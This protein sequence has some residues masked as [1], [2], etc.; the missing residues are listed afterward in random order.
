MRWVQQPVSQEAG[1]WRWRRHHLFVFSAATPAACSTALPAPSSALEPAHLGGLGGA[2]LDADAAQGLAELA[3]AAARGGRPG[4][5]ARRAEACATLLG[6]LRPGRQLQRQRAALSK[7]GRTRRAVLA[8]GSQLLVQR[9]GAGRGTLLPRP[10]GSQLLHWPCGRQDGLF[11]RHSVLAGR[12][13]GGRLD[14][15]GSRRRRRRCW[16][17]HCTQALGRQKSAAW[18]WHI[19]IQGMLHGGAGCC[20]QRRVP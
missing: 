7:G 17:C 6:R 10:L 18:S 2:T 19:Q 12:S 11:H 15:E 9:Q 1:S 13:K 20:G 5:A 16:R 3:G 8:S 4:G 14:A